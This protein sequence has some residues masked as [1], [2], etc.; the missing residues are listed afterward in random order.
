LTT[1]ELDTLPMNFGLTPEHLS[2]VARELV[3]AAS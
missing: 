3:A 1:T 2:H